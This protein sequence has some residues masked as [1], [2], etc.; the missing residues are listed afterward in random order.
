MGGR[1]PSPIDYDDLAEYEGT[2]WLTALANFCAVIG[3]FVGVYAVL[4]LLAA[5]H[6]GFAG[7]WPFL[8]MIAV[9]VAVNVVVRL[10]R[11]RRRRALG[12]TRARRRLRLGLDPGRKR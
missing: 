1:E 7:Y 11:F 10:V 6:R 3:T 5:R 9:A 2:P 12:L 8:V 4:F